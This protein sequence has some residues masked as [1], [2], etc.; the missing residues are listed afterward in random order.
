MTNKDKVKVV[1]GR[2]GRFESVAD[3]QPE[4]D[5]VSETKPST[6]VVHSIAQRTGELRC[7]TLALAENLYNMGL[8]SSNR[9]W[10]ELGQEDRPDQDAPREDCAE[11][12][13]A[14]CLAI[15]HNIDQDRAEERLTRSA[16]QVTANFALPELVLAAKV[17]E[18][19][20]GEFNPELYAI[21]SECRTMSV[22][23]R[24]ENICL[25]NNH[26]AHTLDRI[27]AQIFGDAEEN[28]SEL[29]LIESVDSPPLVEA[30]DRANAVL[31][32]VTYHIEDLRVRMTAA[33][34]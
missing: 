34:M 16:G 26:I 10:L 29:G 27:K 14:H 22:N 1:R 28:V 20:S 15:M 30:L 17:L 25:V 7:V 31:E 33:L 3:T 5:T 21:L 12:S 24:Y 9:V 2:G 4:Q 6:S 18:S 19:Y 23:E 32:A 11:G 8:V 13:L